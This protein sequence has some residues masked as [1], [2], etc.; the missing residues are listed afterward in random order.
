MSGHYGVAHWMLESWRIRRSAGTRSHRGSLP[1]STP[2]WSGAVP[3]IL[4]VVRSN[5]VPEECRCRCDSVV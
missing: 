4:P 1:L 2:T 5:D 3:L